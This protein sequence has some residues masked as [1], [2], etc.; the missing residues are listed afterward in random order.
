MLTS[1]D[2][3][4]KEITKQELTGTN[5]SIYHRE[6]YIDDLSLVYGKIRSTKDINIKLDLGDDPKK[7]EGYE[8][9]SM[10]AAN[11]V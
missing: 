3:P 4:V 11:V 5:Y 10:F 9:Y 8:F 7:H 6:N 1:K 2:L